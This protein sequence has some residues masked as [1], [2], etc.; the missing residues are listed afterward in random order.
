MSVK[1]GR[2]AKITIFDNLVAEMGNYSLSGFNRDVIEHTS[3]GDST[4]TYVAG[5]VDGGEITMSGYY[6][7]TDTDGQRILEAACKAGTIYDPGNIK[8]YIDSTNYF[9]VGPSGHMF[10]TK[11]GGVNVDKYGIAQ[12]DFTIKVVGDA[13][14]LYSATS[15]S[16]SPSPSNSP[17]ISASNSPSGSASQSPSGSPSESPSASPSE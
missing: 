5:H 6:D 11:A 15:K 9:T 1:E 12:T 17:S 3:F 14:T 8:I 10:V 16:I 2:Y 7:V 4:K 13:L